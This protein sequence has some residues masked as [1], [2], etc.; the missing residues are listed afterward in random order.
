MNALRWALFVPGGILIG[1]L[2][3]FPIILF[4][5]IFNLDNIFFTSVVKNAF[6]F[7]FTALCMAWIAP[8]SFNISGF[9]TFLSVS[10]G[11]VIALSSIALLSERSEILVWEY[12]GEVVGL[13]LGYLGATQW[14]KNSLRVLLLNTKGA[15]PYNSY[16]KHSE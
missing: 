10:F 9:K 14:D 6:G 3:A 5:N 13:L 11:V 8:S 15:N 1:F 2:F 4:Y 16:N 7:Y 12:S